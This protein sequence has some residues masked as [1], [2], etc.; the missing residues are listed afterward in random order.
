[1]P[2]SAYERSEMFYLAAL[3]Y[4]ERGRKNDGDRL[5][6]AAVVEDPTLRWPAYLARR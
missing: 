1:M 5:M 3:L 2:Y 4:L 6:R